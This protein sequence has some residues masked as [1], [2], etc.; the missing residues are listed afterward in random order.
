[1]DKTQLSKL[2][3]RELGW[4]QSKY[5]PE[6]FSCPFHGKDNTPSL[7]DTYIKTVPNQGRYGANLFIT[8]QTYADKFDVPKEFWDGPEN[9]GEASWNYLLHLCVTGLKKR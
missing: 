2:I 6:W 1:M 7:H 5:R 8:P 4:K 3:V 9:A